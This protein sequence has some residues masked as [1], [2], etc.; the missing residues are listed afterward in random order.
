M[1][2]KLLVIILLL[3]VVFSKS[4]TIKISGNTN[5]TV[6]KQ[7]LSNALLMAIKFKD[8]SLVN[9]TRTN[10]EGVFKSIKLPVDTYIVIISHPN[11]NDRTYLLVPTKNDTLFNFKNVVLPPKSVELNEVEIIA[12][13]EKMYYKGDTLQFTADSFKVK[14]NASVEDLLKKLP[15]VKVD[16]K[17]KITIQ[18][19]EVDQVLV[20]GDEF[21]G[22]D[23]TIA[24]KNLNAN[25]V[26][27]VQV[28]EKKNESTDD[29]AA[30]TVKILNL[31][32]KEDS[33]KGYFGK[34]SG[35][36]DFN[37]FY[38]NDVLVNKFK[39]QQKFSLF[40]L[41][42]NT[43]KQAFGWDDANKFGL[44]NENN[45]NYDPETNTWTSFNN[46]GTGVP[47]T[48]KSGFYFND[49][50][51]KNTKVNSDYT[52]SQNQL[53]TGSEI[54]TQ[55]FLEDTTYNNQQKIDNTAQNQSHKFN[56]RL[57]QK[58][59]S[60]TELII[61]PK[62]NYTSDKNSNTKTDKFITEN[63]DLTRQTS[64]LNTNSSETIDANVMLK[65]NRNF[66]KK[67]RF[68]VI[69]FQPSYYDSKSNANLN[70]TFNYF[71][72]QAADSSLLQ[73]R[74]TISHREEHNAS[75]TYTE[76]ITKKYKT[77]ISYGFAYNKNNS[78]RNTLDFNGQAYDILN[79]TQSNNFKNLRIVNRVGAKLI[80]DVKKYRISLGTAFRNIYQ[81]NFNVTT[82]Q[83]LSQT[84]INILP[85]ASFNY[86]ISQGSNL[87]VFYAANAQQPDLQQLQPVVDN[88]DPNRI[89][90]GNPNLKPQ[91]TN[92]I[93]FNYYTYKGISDMHFYVGGQ[94][95]N[96]LREINETTTFDDQGKSVT[97]PIN[98]DG[99]FY[100]NIWLGGAFPVLKRFM[101]INTNLS[102]GFN[103]NVAFVNGLKNTTQFLDITPNFGIEKELDY[104][105]V[106]LIAN[107]SYN[108]PWQT[109]TTQ[110]NPYYTYGF[111]GNLMIKLPKKIRINADG[112]YTNNGN[113]AVGYNLNY[114]ILNTSLSKTFLKNENLIVSVEAY[115]I[116][117]QNINNNREI[118]ANKIIDTKTQII[119]RYF[120]ARVIYKFNSNKKKEEED[121]MD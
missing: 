91:F 37:R 48:L 60:L 10:K 8:S 45:N 23:P 12:Y 114:F 36:S 39:K 95:N 103:N 107:Y 101:K 38:E 109:I 110:S 5:D 6:Q 41:L 2:K 65:L 118:S 98:V 11:F 66:M 108:I 1:I 92:N 116:L 87:T 102:S 112:Q 61:K 30:E 57:T 88:T 76:P 104:L 77:E 19:K 14:P 16:A 75:I 73:K 4:Q 35:A 82:N 111:E 27:T 52:F 34:V 120:L 51:G 105:E 22:S 63:G 117:N 96:V 56:F 7:S 67:D 29:N 31:K 13:K 55:F 32:L 46:S 33:K 18:G 85:S 17:G 69:T 54:S 49:K 47:Q 64:I 81:E 83:K 74:T 15:G 59:D 26:E 24:T 9:Y 89:T 40:G 70:T 80:Y 119:K 78:N 115:D 53:L 94:Y 42:A 72:N 113:R 25:T 79:T 86:R 121:E 68:L 90:I 62:I 71:Q 97:T 3:L 28:F 58:L 50:Y 44:S 21:F 20:D 106:S 84:F 43:P 93:N 99:N 100:T